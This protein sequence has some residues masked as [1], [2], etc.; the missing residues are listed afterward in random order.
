MTNSWTR[1]RIAVRDR[2]ADALA[3]IRTS[4]GSEPGPI[5]NAIEAQLEW[6]EGDERAAR[7]RLIKTSK[8]RPLDPHE[9]LVLG[10][11]LLEEPAKAR[12]LFNAA[13]KANL[14]DPRVVEGLGTVA[15]DEGKLDEA[16][17]LLTKAVSA[18]EESWS[19]RFALAM[20]YANKGDAPKAAEHFEAV[21]KMRP[22]YEPAWLGFA[23]FSVLTGQAARAS[24][25]LGPIVES[26]PGRDKLLLAYVDCLASA[27]DIPKA[28][29]AFTLL[30]NKTRDPDL[31]LDFAE[32]CLSGGFIEPADQTLARVARIDGNHRRLWILRGAAE[33]LRE[34]RN[35]P[36]AIEAYEKALESSPKYGRALNAL[37][38]LLMR[39]GEHTDLKRAAQLLDRGAKN[40]KDPDSTASLCNLALLRL[41]E[42]KNAEAAKL[43]KIVLGKANISAGARKQAEKIIADTTA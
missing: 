39:E 40:K 34:P 27:G 20:T 8:E 12:K 19:A 36:R 35:V 29:A 17:R 25:V 14:K 2:D 26:A 18:D 21:C 3:A 38:L 11:L 7:R 32:M 5:Q 41:A 1:T 4:I 22:D 16:E 42:G 33:E 6:A 10:M 43:A 30:A 31:L 28:L 37:G 15:A 23:R 9:K 13:S 24:R